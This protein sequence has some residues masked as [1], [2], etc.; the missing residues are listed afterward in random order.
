VKNKENN[1]L[2]AVVYVHNGEEYIKTFL[3]K[4]NAILDENFKKY[5][6]VVVNDSSNDNTD[7]IVKETAKNLGNDAVILINTGFYQGI[8]NSMLAGVDFSSGDF[9]FEFDSIIIDYEIDLIMKIYNRCLDGYD[10][11]GASPDSKKV[12]S[13]QLFYKVFNKFSKSQFKIQTESF[14]IVSRRAINR[15]NQIS[16]NILYRKA[17]YASCGLK[18]DSIVYDTVKNS[19]IHLVHKPI[20][21]QELAF[22]S[23]LVFTN[24]A[25]KIS[26]FL[27]L[28]MMIFSLS[29]GIYA[30]IVFIKDI[31]IAGWTTTML[32][33]SIGFLGVFGIFSI[34]IKYLSV[35][36]KLLFKKTKYVISNIEKL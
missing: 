30:L 2:S 16:S 26:S 17:I 24:V 19:Q 7:K 5:E 10:I 33:L 14:R 13:S 12:K 8:E 25:Y 29:I 11:V 22:D 35:I 23:L 34:I 6:I 18:Y 3:E 20:Y 21:R 28:L 9:V 27:T 4:I 31:P 15:I 36:I 1:F 32:V